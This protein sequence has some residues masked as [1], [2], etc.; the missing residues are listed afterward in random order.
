MLAAQATYEANAW[1]PGLA[2]GVNANQPHIEA[3]SKV[4]DVLSIRSPLTHLAANRERTREEE[5]SIQS[6]KIN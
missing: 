4:T 3:T 2:R 1:K 6:G 5:C